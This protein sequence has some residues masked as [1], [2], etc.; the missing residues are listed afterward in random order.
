MTNLNLAATKSTPSVAFD[1]ASNTLEFSGE[2]YPENSIAFYQTI[3][4][5]L[6]AYLA[7]NHG[8]LTVSFKLVYFNTS[9]SKCLL[10]LLECLEKHHEQYKNIAIHW[11]Y[12]EGDEDM[13]ES[14]V[15]FSLEVKL[16]FEL[17]PLPGN[18]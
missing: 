3:Q 8:P 7:E 17:I 14:G 15:D 2:S 18:S 10:D 13:Q 5:Q 12:P 9:S 4:Q 11:Y 16:S 6:E 1:P